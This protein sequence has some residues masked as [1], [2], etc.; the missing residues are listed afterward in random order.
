VAAE[1]AVFE[2]PQPALWIELQA[3]DVPMPITPDLVG[4]RRAEIGERIALCSR[5]IGLQTH[6]GAEV[7]RQILGRFHLLAIARGYEQ[8][9]A[10]RRECEAMR[11]MATA[12][13]F[14]LLPPDHLQVAQFTIRTR[15]A[16]QIGSADR[17]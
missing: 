14:G 17:S 9:L 4:G 15:R 11:I 13:H 7:V 8:V 10:I 6:D 5:S 16:Y 3:K 1:R 2:R 12:G